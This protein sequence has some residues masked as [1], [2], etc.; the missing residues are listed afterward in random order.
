VVYVTGP[1][2]LNDNYK[3]GEY[4]GCDRAE[5]RFE[6][7]EEIYGRVSLREGSEKDGWSCDLERSKTFE[8]R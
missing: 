3:F 7:D 2:A 4:G 5:D 6:W 1:A 8:L